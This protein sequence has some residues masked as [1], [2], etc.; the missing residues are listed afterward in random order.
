MQIYRTGCTV[1]GGN[2]GVHFTFGPDG[3]ASG[4]AF[5]VL[6]SAEDLEK[7]LTKTK[8]NIGHRY[9]DGVYFVNQLTC[10]SNCSHLQRIILSL[11]EAVLFPTGDVVH[12]EF[13]FG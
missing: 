9:I 4:E 12:S 5:V 10:V 1:E 11:P 13:L 6:T 7:A 3:R 2:D 8:Q